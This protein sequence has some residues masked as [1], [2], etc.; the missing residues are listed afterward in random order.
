VNYFYYLN[1]TPYL[2]SD[3]SGGNPTVRPILL[4][5]Y[6]NYYGLY[7]DLPVQ[8]DERQ[9]QSLKGELILNIGVIVIQDHV[10]WFN[11][12]RIQVNAQVAG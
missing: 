5:V 12:R 2:I 11:R 7:T 3:K 1:G 6:I 4:N 8:K 9:G 10:F